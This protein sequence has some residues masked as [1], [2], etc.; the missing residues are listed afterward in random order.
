MSIE[1]TLKCNTS[2]KKFKVSYPNDISH[3][4]RKRDLDGLQITVF[5]KKIGTFGVQKR[6]NKSNDSNL[7]LRI[8]AKTKDMLPIPIFADQDIS[9]RAKY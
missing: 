1:K 4:S 2:F 6:E 3:R 9:Q 7:N 5:C 8:F